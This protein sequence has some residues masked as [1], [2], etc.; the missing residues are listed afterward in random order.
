MEIST[1]WPRPVRR[2]AARASSAPIAAWAPARWKACSRG[3]TSGGPSRSPD[4]AIMPPAAHATRSVP[5]HDARGPD[6]PKGVTTTWIS[7]GRRRASSW[8]ENGLPVPPSI[9]LST[10]TSAPSTSLR[11]ASRSDRSDR[12]SATVRFPAFQW[13]NAT[14][15]SARIRSPPGGSTRTTSAPRPTRTRVAKIPASSVRSR[16]RIRASSSPR[17]PRTRRPPGRWWARPTTAPRAA[18]RRAGRHSCRTAPTSR[19]AP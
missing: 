7:S 15:A 8:C 4:S 12:S 3:G 6:S 16:T 10:S 19:D 1:S 14:G 5:F 13:S 2:R 18:S 11:N 9:A 17:T